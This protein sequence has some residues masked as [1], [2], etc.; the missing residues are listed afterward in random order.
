MAANTNPIFTLTPNI[1]VGQ[2]ISAANTAKDGTGTV[3]TIHTAGANGSLVY[4][5]NWQPL[6]T[7]I[8]SVGRVFINN[9][10]TNTTAT[11]NTYFGDIS[12]PATT[13]SE[14]AQIGKTVQVMNVALPAGYK[15][16]VVIGTA[17]AAGFAVSAIAEDY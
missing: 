5:V 9:G 7:N 14:V 17:V 4:S 6:G 12:L 16:L 11:N 3:V 2:T 13:N 8:A 15:L 1:T 10:S